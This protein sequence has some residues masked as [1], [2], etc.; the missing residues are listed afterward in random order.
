MCSFYF[1]VGQGIFRE[2][3]KCGIFLGQNTHKCPGADTHFTGC[4]LTPPT[5]LFSSLSPLTRTEGL[6]KQ[7]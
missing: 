3:D 4:F 2:T 7:I 5:I 1:L 6:G